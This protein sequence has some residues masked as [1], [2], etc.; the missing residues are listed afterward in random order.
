MTL[1]GH[2][3]RPC[4]LLSHIVYLFRYLAAMV[5]T[6]ITLAQ[7]NKLRGGKEAAQ[8][9]IATPNRTLEGSH[10]CHQATHRHVQ[11]RESRRQ[12]WAEADAQRAY[13]PHAAPTAQAQCR[14]PV[15]PGGQRPG[16]VGTSPA[17]AGVGTD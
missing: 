5:C 12:T 13:R 9:V 3:P 14:Y 8:E 7:G 15:S 17:F 2:L 1:Y 11:P 10:P 4:E 6:G 16:G